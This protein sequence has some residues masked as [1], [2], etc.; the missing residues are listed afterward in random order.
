MKGL[1]ILVDHDSSAILQFHDVSRND[2]LL[3]HG[4]L[5]RERGKGDE[6]RDEQRSLHQTFHG[7][8]LDDADVRGYARRGSLD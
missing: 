6:G 2:E 3:P 1:A 8:L 4:G 7:D 5:G